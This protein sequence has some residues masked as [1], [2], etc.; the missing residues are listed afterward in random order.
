MSRKTD[1]YWG[2]LQ[3]SAARGFSADY[4]AEKEKL[5]EQ[6]K[7]SMIVPHSDTPADDTDEKNPD[8][9][10]ANPAPYKGPHKS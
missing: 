5:S 7:E 3:G 8:N 10:L 9:E 2:P 4:D 6:L 1:R